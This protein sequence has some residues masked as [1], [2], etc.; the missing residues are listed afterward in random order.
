MAT[1]TAPAPQRSRNYWQLP[2]FAVGIAAAI[3]AWTAFPPLPRNPADR[4]VSDQAALREALDRK[5]TDLGTIERLAPLVSD[6]AEQFP[7]QSA[8]A[9][10]L[11]GSGY[12]ALAEASPDNGNL[13][14]EAARNLAKADPSKLA[15]PVDKTKVTYRRSKARAA[16]GDGDPKELIPVLARPPAGEEVDGERRRILAE[17]YLRAVP[18]DPKKARDEFKTYLGGQTKLS[19]P[20]LARC[21]LRLAESH[22]AAEEPDLARPWLKEIGQG[23]PADVLALSKLLQARLAVAD[24]N[25]PEAVKL[26]EAALTG[27]G[28]PN[29]LRGPARYQTGLAFQKMMNSKDA[30]PYFAL[31]AKDPGPVAAAASAKLAVITVT[32]PTT[33]GSVSRA[34][35][36]LEVM[37]QDTPKGTEFRNPFITTLEAQAAFEAVIQV[38]LN[39]GDYT[40]AVRASDAYSAVAVNDRDRERRAE[41]RAAWATSLQKTDTVT[42]ASL[43]RLAA[44]DY[45]AL[46]TTAK[47]TIQADHLKR[48]V[49]MYRQSG[50]EKAAFAAIERLTQ[51]TGLNNDAAASAWV[52]KGDL[53]LASG[54]FNDGVEALKKAMAT[55]GPSATPARVKLAI[56]YLEQGRTKARTPGAGQT[57]APGLIEFAQNLFTQ[58]ANTTAELPVEKDAQQTALYE[59]GKLLLQ[60]Q[61]YPDAE[62]RF[63]QL[64]QTYPTAPLAGQARLYLGSCLLLIARGDH[65]GGRPPAD[66]DRKLAEAQK[67][68]EELAK[69]TDPFL[70][71]Q[72]DV[73]LANTTLL[74]KKYDDMPELC[75]RLAEKYP[76]KVEELLVLSMLYWSYL[77]SDR[78][79]PAAR[80][81]IY[82]EATFEK[83]KPADYMNG[84]EEYTRE[85]WVKW[86][87][88]TKPKM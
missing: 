52:E 67:V 27:S 70:S 20:S 1:D 28:L 40:S 34:V 12:L 87:E 10:Y 56:A 51:I 48:A 25:W 47:D 45:L 74:M 24:S 44:E 83:L 79:E 2:T 17:T 55:P 4:F 53:L 38:G 5:P 71:A 37:I 50:D 33:K 6:G 21:K 22:L 65:Q 58:V 36:L 42:A 84:A 9:H 80:T 73:R 26:F 76:S 41:V 43:Y 46:A 75:K 81:R 14:A 82:M 8:S 64:V 72:A 57:E 69:S 18:Q 32:D 61:N 59:L 7:E 78:P 77:A 85:Y 15:S 86:F 66:A 19:A 62:A 88:S 31:A 23:A 63:R 29:N 68:F 11:A 60:Q 54:Q 13:W 30:G 49:A 35:E 3:A 16:I 39:N